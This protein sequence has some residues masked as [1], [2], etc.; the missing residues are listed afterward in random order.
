MCAA[1]KSLPVH[2]IRAV[3]FSISQIVQHDIDVVF[4]V[5]FSFSTLP[6][7]LGWFQYSRF[8]SLGYCLITLRI[9]GLLIKQAP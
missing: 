7:R 6:F 5:Q 1:V 8:H 2:S 3:I 9:W 4:D